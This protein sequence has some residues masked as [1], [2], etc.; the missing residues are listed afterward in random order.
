MAATWIKSLH[1]NKGKT[2]LQSLI[3]RTDYAENPEKT[4]GGQLI[5]GYSCTPRTAAVQFAISK[6]DYEYKT[7]RNN[8]KSNVIAYHIRQSFKPG[9]IDAQTAN[10][11]GY[12]LVMSFTKGKHAFIVATHTDKKHIHNHI[13]LRLRSQYVE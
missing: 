3:E 2:L 5:T 9:E 10:K 4:K 8:G 1:I 12:E 7:G 11:I 13:I 6:R